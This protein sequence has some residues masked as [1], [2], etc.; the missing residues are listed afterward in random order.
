M[1]QGAGPVEK[2][3][4][5]RSSPA[6]PVIPPEPAKIEVPKVVKGPQK[7]LPGGNPTL[8][9]QLASRGAFVTSPEEVKRAIANP[10]IRIIEV[11]N[12]CTADKF[13]DAAQ[14]KRLQDWVS[15][16]GVLWATNDVLKLFGVPHSKPLQG[17]G[18]L[19]SLVSGSVEVADILKDCKK[20]AVK[21]AADRVYVLGLNKNIVPLLKL[22]T[23]V[24]SD[25]KAGTADWSMIPYGKGWISDPKPI[26]TAQ[27][28]SERFWFNFCLFC[29]RQTVAPPLPPAPPVRKKLVVFGKV[30]GPLFGVWVSPGGESM[31]I[32]DN[33]AS[34]TLNVTRSPVLQKLT[35]TLERVR[36]RTDFLKY[37]GILAVKFGRENA[38]YQLETTVTAP[39][40]GRSPIG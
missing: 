38:E 31:I 3:P 1:G 25:L 36:G 23:D 32:D 39:S 13:A 17:D 2:E 19:D 37:R 29:L 11:A 10:N 30:K 22:E 12:V 4:H 6:R 33:E 27:Y 20:V 8:D 7:P 26:D 28:D 18:E 15:N 35:G 9:E 21:E 16:G 5:R 24:S 34:I 40:I 14:V